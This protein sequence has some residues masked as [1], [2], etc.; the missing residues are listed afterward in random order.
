MTLPIRRSG[1][2]ARKVESKI[3]QMRVRALCDQP[4]L[5]MDAF[6][7][8]AGQ[9]DSL[10]DGLLGKQILRSIAHVACSDLHSISARLRTRRKREDLWNLREP[11]RLGNGKRPDASHNG[12]S[13]Q[14]KRLARNTAFAPRASCSRR[15]SLPYTQR[16]PRDAPPRDNCTVRSIVDARPPSKRSVVPSL[17]TAR[18]VLLLGDCP[19]VIWLILRR[20]E[21]L[22]TEFVLHMGSK[23]AQLLKD[24]A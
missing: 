8:L 6:G 13:P 2:P 14:E 18:S 20:G 23:L 16:Y 15:P 4:K 11:L 19:N 10:H 3:S 5:A 24:H 22:L 7:C 9:W 12:Q 1:A 17:R 21:H